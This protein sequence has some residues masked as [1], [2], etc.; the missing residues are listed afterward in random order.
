MEN[1]DVVPNH[2]TSGVRGEFQGV[3]RNVGLE[4]VNSAA[5]HKKQQKSTSRNW[6]DSTVV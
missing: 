6:L 5:P 1:S 3:V 4:F 2:I